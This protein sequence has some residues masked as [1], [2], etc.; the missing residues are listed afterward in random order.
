VGVAYGSDV[1]LVKKTLLEIALETPGVLKYPRPDVIF[2]D[3][4]DSA[5]IFRLRIWVDVDDY[6]TVASQIRFEID[7]R[8]SDLQIEIAFPQRDLHIR[9]LPERMDKVV[10]PYNSPNASPEPQEG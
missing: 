4:A 2:V 6:W 10:C 3:H 5:L 1:E 7:Q 8:F 9:T